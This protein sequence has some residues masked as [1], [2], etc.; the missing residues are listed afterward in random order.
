MANG[1]A[2]TAGVILCV[3]VSLLAAGCSDSPSKIVEFESEE[4]TDDE[5]GLIK[6]TKGH[7]IFLDPGFSSSQGDRQRKFKP[8]SQDRRFH[9][10]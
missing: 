1:H 9:E 4:T 10:F 3:S 8:R 5:L 7:Q 2:T 6:T